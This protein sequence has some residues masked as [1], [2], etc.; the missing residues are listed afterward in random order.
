[1]D[2]QRPSSSLSSLKS[3]SNSLYGRHEFDSLHIRDEAQPSHFRNAP[4]VN[5]VFPRMAVETGLAE[6]E[7]DLAVRR[8]EMRAA[9]ALLEGS[10]TREAAGTSPA[11]QPA[12]RFEKKEKVQEKKVRIPVFNNDSIA[13]HH[14]DAEAVEQMYNAP[15]NCQIKRSNAFRENIARR[16]KREQKEGL[17]APAF[18]ESTAAHHCEAEAVDA[19]HNAPQVSQ[20]ERSNAV[21]E[22]VLRRKNAQFFTPSTTLSSIKDEPNFTSST[23]LWSPGLAVRNFSRMWPT[24]TELPIIIVTPPSPPST[25]VIPEL[26]R[27]DS[28][29]TFFEIDH[30]DDAPPPKTKAVPTTAGPTTPAIKLSGNASLSKARTSNF[31]R[32]L[33]PSILSNQRPRASTATAAELGQELEVLNVNVLRT[34]T[35]GEWLAGYPREQRNTLP[36]PTESEWMARPREAR[37][38]PT[39]TESEWMATPREAR[40]LPTPTEREWM[41]YEARGLPA[42]P[43]GAWL[44]GRV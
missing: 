24:L 13:A 32:S 26:E 39:P 33:W 40:T 43:E 21:S 19:M 34:P 2:S 42:P 1:M 23:I 35:E 18:N 31:W 15:Q 8:A 10:I 6:M 36:S 41:A 7:F 20:I 25:A 9:S 27:R 16:M 28:A 11:H 12:I 3:K 5:R 37:V 4:Y 44:A 22:K 38:M 29:H 14:G 17:R 30:N